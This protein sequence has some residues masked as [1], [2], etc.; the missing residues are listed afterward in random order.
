[1][2]GGPVP[3][4]HPYAFARKISRLSVARFAARNARLAEEEGFEPPVPLFSV[5]AGFRDRWLYRSPIP[6]LWRRVQDLNL[7]RL[8]A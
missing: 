2:R 7:R 6:P 4:D 5:H 3:R 1:M 8:R